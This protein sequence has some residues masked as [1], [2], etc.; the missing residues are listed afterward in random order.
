MTVLHYRAL[1]G[2]THCLKELLEFNNNNNININIQNNNAC[3]SLHLAVKN[4]K[5]GCVKALLAHPNVNINRK[6]NNG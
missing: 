5:F 4:G 1:K 3:T 6:N 2:M